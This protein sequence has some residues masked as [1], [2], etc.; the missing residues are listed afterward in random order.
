MKQTRIYQKLWNMHLYK[1]ET[2][3]QED[4]MVENPDI[5]RIK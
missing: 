5:L 1:Q 2:P 3:N 4:G